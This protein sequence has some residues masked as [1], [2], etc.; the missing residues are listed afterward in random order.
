MSKKQRHQIGCAAVNR[1]REKEGGDGRWTTEAFI[2]TVSFENA[3]E[4]ALRKHTPFIYKLQH[5]SGKTA[6]APLQQLNS[7]RQWNQRQR[8]QLFKKW[9]LDS[10]FY[11][12]CVSK[13]SNTFSI[14]NLRRFSC[15]L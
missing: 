1:G 10:A 13:H 5:K 2:F 11:C 9:V 3:E 14:A 4:A 6:S 8:W 15:L 12:G 7:R